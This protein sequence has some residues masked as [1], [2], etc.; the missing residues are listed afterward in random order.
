MREYNKSIKGKLFKYFKQRLKIKRSTSGWWRCDCPF[1]DATFAFGINLEKKSTKCFRCPE[2]NSP[3]TLLMKLERFETYAEASKFLNIQQEY[4]SYEA[5][6]YRRIERKE[7]QLPREFT[8]IA[9]ADGILGKGAQRYMKKRGFDITEM[10]MKGVGYCLSGEYEGY[11][12]FPFYVKGKLVFFQ[13]R[14]FIGSGPKM[15]NPA[16]ETFGVGKTDWIYNQDALFMYKTIYLVESITNANTIGDRAIAIGGKDISDKQLSLI[17]GSPCSN[18]IILLDDD[19]IKQ[20][21]QLALQ[22][23]NYKK[24]KLIPMPEKKDVN[25]LGKKRTI[26]L[27]TKENYKTYNEFYKMYL[28]I[29]EITFNTH[30][31]RALGY[32]YSRGA[33]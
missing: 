33:A 7:V 10:A 18:L 17:L 22:T 16:K 2:S 4:E 21:V 24:T 3:I 11:I 13:G 32:S 6:T 29:N 20:A 28:N 25:D 19:A 26:A 31:R 27:V 14:K 12:I 1:C 15:K 8:S 30:H 9:V 23:V 5:Y